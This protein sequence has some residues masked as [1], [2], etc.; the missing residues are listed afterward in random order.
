MR[1]VSRIVPLALAVALVA[2]LTGCR[3]DDVAARV[4][5]EAIKMSV[6]EQQLEDTKKQY[7]QMFEGADAE[8][9]LLD[10]RQ[11]ILDTLISQE[12]LRQAAEDSGIE[13]DEKEIDNQVNELKKSFQGDQK[14]E[15]ALKKAN[16]TVDKL[17]DQLREQMVQ[18]K[19]VEKLTA[20]IKIA[21]KDIKAYYDK[22]KAQYKEEAA[23]HAAHILFDERDEANA[24]KVLEMVEDGD[25]FAAL[26][27]KYSKD[28]VSATK[29]GDLGWPTQ[30]YVSEFQAAADKLDPGE[31]SDL[32]KSPFG[33]HI[34]KV[35]EKRS[36]RQKKLD[37]VKEQIRQIL[38]QQQQAEAYTKY[39]EGLRKDA[40]IEIVDPVLKAAQVTTAP[41]GS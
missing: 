21:D 2:A 7:P 26:A 10:F 23:V 39:L 20:E 13:I 35:I 16:L 38:T 1:F 33:W 15:E 4:N 37:E 11:R 41:A 5:G 40:K 32:V 29:G 36:E 17:K 8:A 24:E 6:I 18:Q 27:K 19:L 28:T 25:D 30:P 22:N 12:L 3:D 34:I 31:I 9:R 14:F